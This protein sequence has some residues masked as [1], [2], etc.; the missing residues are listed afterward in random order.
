MPPECVDGDSVSF[1]YDASEKLRRVLRARKGDV[2]TVL[3][4]SGFERKVR[5]DTVDQGF[6]AATVLATGQGFGEPLIFITLYQALLKSSR[7]EYALQKGVESGVSKFVPYVC[8]RTEMALPGDS[9]KRRW[10][11]IIKEASEQ[12]GRS[13]IPEL[14]ETVSFET[15]VRSV[16]CSAIIPWE[17][18]KGSLLRGVLTKILGNNPTEDSKLA[19]F[20]GPAGGFTFEEILLAKEAG[21]IPVSLGSR[22]LRSETAGV[23]T[24]AS[25]LYEA[26][27][28]G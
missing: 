22:I 18:E 19:I 21:I 14:S 25:V 1:P 7:F 9:R 6:C 8:E 20:I 17:E 12:S 16:S 5:L 13:L 2:V 10:R 4:G 26:G 11:K 27:E 3:D 24:V 23:F 15:A 28:M